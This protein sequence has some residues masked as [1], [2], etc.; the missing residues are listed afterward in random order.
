MIVPGND[1]LSALPFQESRKMQEFQRERINSSSKTVGVFG[2]SM[3]TLRSPA[4]SYTFSGLYIRW[5][6]M[7]HSD[8]S[9]NWC[10]TSTTW[11]KRIRATKGWGCKNYKLNK[12][13]TKQA[14]PQVSKMQHRDQKRETDDSP[15]A[16]LITVAS[17]VWASQL[18]DIGYG[19]WRSR[20]L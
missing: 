14:E 17:P 4:K 1:S 8:W 5:S 19:M 3:A 12:K 11:W 7:L 18:E 9:A 20:N 16:C 15:T 2:V 6:C 10:P 13:P